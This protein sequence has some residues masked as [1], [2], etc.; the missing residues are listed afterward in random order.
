M[1]LVLLYKRTSHTA[2]RSRQVIWQLKVCAKGSSK[3]S[4]ITKDSF[5][6]TDYSMKCTIQ[7]RYTLRQLIFN[8]SLCL[9]TLSLWGC[10]HQ[11]TFLA[12]DQK[13]HKSLIKG[14]HQWRFEDQ[15]NKAPCELWLTGIKWF[16]STATCLIHL[17][18]MWIRLDAPMCSNAST[19]SI[20]I[21]RTM[22]LN[23]NKSCQSSDTSWPRLLTGLLTE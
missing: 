15:S 5:R 1:V 12:R 14:Y 22:Y 20:M 7:T 19:I 16:L 10:I 21:Q 13:N 9:H 3:E 2:S 11:K 17:G 23:H 6:T 8:V 18:I 4:S